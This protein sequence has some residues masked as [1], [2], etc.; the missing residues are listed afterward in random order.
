MTA[1]PTPETQAFILL[2]KKMPIQTKKEISV[3]FQEH[4]NTWETS[5]EEEDSQ[6]WMSVSSDA[7]A[8]IWG[9]PAED[10]WDEIY[11]KHKADGRLQT[12]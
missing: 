5:T 10:V 6:F 3:W 1:Q 9:D 2:F 8:D 11:K 7:F 4:Q 12:I